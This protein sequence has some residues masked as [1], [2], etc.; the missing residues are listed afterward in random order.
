ML[1]VEVFQ[2]ETQE[3]KNP[4]VTSDSGAKYVGGKGTYF[5]VPLLDCLDLLFMCVHENIIFTMT[6]KVQKKNHSAN[7]C[8]HKK[9]MSAD[10][11]RLKFCAAF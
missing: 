9:K 8:I 3:R 11:K 1:Y 5:I 10:F 7:K 2:K 6:K 4:V